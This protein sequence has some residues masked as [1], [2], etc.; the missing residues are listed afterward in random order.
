[1]QEVQKHFISKCNISLPAACKTGYFNCLLG[2][3]EDLQILQKLYQEAE[4]K[5]T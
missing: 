4:M 5:L 2:W 1:M 3:E